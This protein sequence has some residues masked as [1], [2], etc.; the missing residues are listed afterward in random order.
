MPL[1]W[2]TGASAGCF[3]GVFHKKTEEAAVL[4]CNSLQTFWPVLPQ[5][6]PRKAP[7]GRVEFQESLLWSGAL[8]SLQKP[9]LRSGFSIERRGRKVLQVIT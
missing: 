7:P 4:P 5:Q 2:Q 8:P 3:V 6:Q 9:W 1:I